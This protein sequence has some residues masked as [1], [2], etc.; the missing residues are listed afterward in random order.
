MGAWQL[1]AASCMPP[2]GM[3]MQRGTHSYQSRQTLTGA[4]KIYASGSSTVLLP[5]PTMYILNKPGAKPAG[6]MAQK[7]YLQQPLH[8]ERTEMQ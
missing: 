5:K 1:I 8:T 7:A 3:H 4:N 6:P 2:L